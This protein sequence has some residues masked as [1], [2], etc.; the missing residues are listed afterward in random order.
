MHVCVRVRV[1][2]C[3]CVCAVV[4]VYCFLRLLC[5]GVCVEYSV[6]ILVQLF[7]TLKLKNQFKEQILIF[8]NRA[9]IDVLKNCRKK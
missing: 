6:L 8:F 4:C 3:V 9:F 2:V 5:C 7:N 1:C